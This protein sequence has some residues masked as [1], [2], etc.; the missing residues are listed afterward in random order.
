MTKFVLSG[1]VS[2]ALISGFAAGLTGCSLPEPS[3][4]NTKRVEVH[5]RFYSGRFETVHFN[6]GL[7]GDVAHQYDRFGDGPIYVSVTYDPAVR[8]NDALSAGQ[9]LSRISS[10]LYKKGV[11]GVEGAILPV[12]ESGARSE[13]LVEY[14]QYTAHKPS[15]CGTMPGL[16]GEA[17]DMFEAGSYDYGCSIETQISR[18]IRRPKDLLGDSAMDPAIGARTAN[19][20]EGYKTGT[21]N[22]QLEGEQASD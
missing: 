17:T 2:F 4:L 19:I 20:Y 5:E 8:Q 7:A 21:P 11:R 13:V 16:E 1:F 6:A 3:R 22:E 14:R 12:R 15:G 9:E 18:Q 10:L